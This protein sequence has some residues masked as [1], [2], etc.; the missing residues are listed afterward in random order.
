MTT[1]VEL[2]GE[3]YGRSS[4][5]TTGD[6]GLNSLGGRGLSEDGAIIALVGNKGRILWQ[7]LRELFGQGKVGFVPTG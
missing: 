1:P 5:R 2:C 3:W 4:V 7:A 6:A